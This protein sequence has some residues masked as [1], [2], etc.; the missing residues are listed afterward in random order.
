MKGYILKVNSSDISKAVSYPVSLMLT[1]TWVT[2]LLFEGLRP[3]IG[4]WTT[5][6]YTLH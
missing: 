5:L 2:D 4:E 1:L 3:K 6:H